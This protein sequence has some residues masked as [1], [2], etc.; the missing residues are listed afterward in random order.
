M[1]T[2]RKIKW[3]LLCTIFILIAVALG[4]TQNSR[5]GSNSDPLM[6]GNHQSQSLSGGHYLLTNH[7]Q[8]SAQ[9][10]SNALQ[11]GSY[12]L[13]QPESTDAV[14]GCCCKNYLACIRKK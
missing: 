13:S 9:S 1:H 8:T 5:A 14:T 7:T 4:S 12:L 3:I 10:V 11:G 2:S 6:V